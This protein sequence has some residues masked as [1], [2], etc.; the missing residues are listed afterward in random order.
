MHSDLNPSRQGGSLLTC[1]MPSSGLESW[2]LCMCLFYSLDFTERPC[3][4]F[5]Y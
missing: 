2:G 5:I 1:G 3:A 4:I